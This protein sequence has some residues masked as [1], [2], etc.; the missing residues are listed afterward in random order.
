MDYQKLQDISYNDGE[1]ESY[2]HNWEFKE[3]TETVRVYYKQNETYNSRLTGFR[4][5]A[6]SWTGG[7]NEYWDLDSEFEIIYQGIAQFDGVRHLYMGDDYNDSKGYIYYPSLNDHI[8][9]FKTLQELQQLFCQKDQ[10]D[11]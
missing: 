5:L 3:L 9:V 11:E 10:L 1:K 7:I 8:L 4:F 2:V 6:L